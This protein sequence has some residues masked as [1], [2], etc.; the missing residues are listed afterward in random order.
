MENLSVSYLLCNDVPVK[1]EEGDVEEQSWSIWCRSKDEENPC[2]ICYLHD[3]GSCMSGQMKHSMSSAHNKAAMMSWRC[4]GSYH[5]FGM[6][7]PFLHCGGPICSKFTILWFPI[8]FGPTVVM[9]C[10]WLSTACDT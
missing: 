7:G 8:A 5:L 3:K 2:H 4:A 9:V 6:Q 10:K 1:T